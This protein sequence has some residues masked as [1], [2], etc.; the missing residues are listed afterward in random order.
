MRIINFVLFL[1]ILLFEPPHQE[2]L[3]YKFID[4]LHELRD[5]TVGAVQSLFSFP[6]KE[7]FFEMSKNGILGYPVG[8]VFA[9]INEF[10]K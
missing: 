7:E 9:F 2:C 3:Q 4:A 6:T 1:C 8:A 10:C 5:T